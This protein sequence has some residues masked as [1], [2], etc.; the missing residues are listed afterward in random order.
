M[1]KILFAGT[2]L[3]TL[4][5]SSP[6]Y[7]ADMAFKAPWDPGYSWSGCYLGGQ[8][9][10]GFM[11][12][13]VVAN[14]S[15]GSSSYNNTGDP[16][17]HAGG[18]IA[19]GQLG[20]N[21]QYRQAVFGVEGEGWWSNLTDRYTDSYTDFYPSSGSGTET[22]A[23]NYQS[24]LVNRWD[25]AISLRAGWAFDRLMLYGKAGFVWGKFNYSQIHMERLTPTIPV[26][27]IANICPIIPAAR[28]CR[29][30]CLASAW[31]TRLPIIGP[32]GSRQ[33]T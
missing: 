27:S 24:T 6:L 13:N 10:G 11:K 15:E 33:I 30:C 18:A 4:A 7:A 2:A 3:V 14:D 22:Y 25:M 19:G 21:Y 23:Y 28:F 9:G 5:V 16:I 17:F 1:K 32:Q 26:A 12:D 8:V 29:E 20:C 31:N